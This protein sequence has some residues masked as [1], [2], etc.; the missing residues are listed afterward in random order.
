MIRAVRSRM[1]SS[2]TAC[3]DDCTPGKGMGRTRGLIK[4]SAWLHAVSSVTFTL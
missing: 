4:V 3:A 1:Y 2:E